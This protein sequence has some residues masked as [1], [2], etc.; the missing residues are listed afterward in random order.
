MTVIVTVF[1]NLNLKIN[2]VKNEGK[3]KNNFEILNLF[4]IIQIMSETHELTLKEYYES[5]GQSL[6]EE[7]E[8]ENMIVS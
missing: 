3:I 4:K 2:L 8:E 1:K 7:F 6:H 5:F